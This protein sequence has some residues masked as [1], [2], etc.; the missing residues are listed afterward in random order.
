MGKEVASGM[1]YGFLTS[2][3]EENSDF[4]MFL[5]CSP[6]HSPRKGSVTWDLSFP[7]WSCAHT[8]I[9][10]LGILSEMLKIQQKLVP[11]PKTLKPKSMRSSERG[12][13][14]GTERTMI[15]PRSP[16]KSVAKDV[17]TPTK[18]PH[19]TKIFSCNAKNPLSYI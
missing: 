9:S 8:C 14:T 18:V 5:A 6:A 12:G 16:N 4:F 17:P 15:Y 19:S 10:P 1:V 13:E 3:F 11:T 2:A 7:G